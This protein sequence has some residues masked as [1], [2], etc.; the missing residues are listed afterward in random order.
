MTEHTP[1]TSQQWNRLIELMRQCPPRFHEQPHE[2]VERC[3]KS[4]GLRPGLLTMTHIDLACDSARKPRWQE[5]A[6]P[7]QPD[8]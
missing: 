5:V 3:T 6:D 2:L 8:K 1:Y 7:N 4:M